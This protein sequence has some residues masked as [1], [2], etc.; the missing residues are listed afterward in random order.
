MNRDTLIG[1]GLGLVIGLLGGYLLGS[2]AGNRSDRIPAVAQPAAGTPAPAQ[3]GGATM[4]GRIS[5]LEQITAREPQNVQAW[6]ELGH[7]YF[8][9]RQPAKAVAAY[10]RA[11]AIQPNNPDVLT[12]QGIMYRDLGRPDDALKNFQKAASLDPNHMQ[13]R[14]NQGIVLAYDKKDPQKAIAVW[15]DLVKAAPQS[16]QAVQAKQLIAELQGQPGSAPAAPP[17][18]R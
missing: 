10:D 1:L 18:Q 11:L 12:D 3:Q 4:S 17:Q 9:T 13:S 7:A 6:I 14:F 5:M 15:N 2:T 8:D 16:P